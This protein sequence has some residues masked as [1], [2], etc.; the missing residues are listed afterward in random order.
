MLMDKNNCLL[1][2]KIFSTGFFSYQADYINMDKDSLFHI[3]DRILANPLMFLQLVKTILTVRYSK[4]HILLS[5]C[6]V[7]AFFTAGILFYQSQVAQTQIDIDGFKFWHSM[8]HCYPLVLIV[9]TLIGRKMELSREENGNK[10]ERY[11]PL[12]SDRVL[13]KTEKHIIKVKN[14]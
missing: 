3:Y 5:T 11:H 10:K 6:D 8:W 13:A 14:I 7:T 1:K 9:T 4:Q 12:L 2:I